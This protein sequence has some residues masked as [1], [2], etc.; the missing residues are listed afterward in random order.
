MCPLELRATPMPSPMYTLGGSF[1]KSLTTSNLMS[2]TSFA[3]GSSFICAGV[4]PPGA[5][6]GAWACAWASRATAPPES[7][8][9]IARQPIL[10]SFIRHLDDL[11]ERELLHAPVHELGDIQGVGI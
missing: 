11:L 8:S 5:G 9:A 1:M 10:R 2:G 3:L 6:G 7:D 4:R